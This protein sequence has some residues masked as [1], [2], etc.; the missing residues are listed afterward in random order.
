MQKKENN[1][2]SVFF[3]TPQFVTHVLD[4]L[5]DANLKPT[6]IVTAHEKP[7][8]R[9]LL[10]KPSPVKVWGQEHGVEVREPEKMDEAFIA[11]LGTDFDLFIV[12]GYGK[13]LP[14]ELLKL[15]Q[16]GTLNVHPS[17]LPKF[18]GP[19]PIESQILEDSK[20]VGVSVIRLD[21]ETDHGPILAQKSFSPS[22]WPMMRSELEELLWSEGGN[23]LA[24]SIPPYIE[25]QL[26]PEEQNHVL[27]TFTPKLSKADGLLD[28]SGDSYKNYL[29]YCAYERWPGTYFFTERNGKKVQVS[30][31]L[32][33]TSFGRD[34]SKFSPRSSL[35]RVKITEAS[36]ENGTFK[37]LRVIPEGKG[38][39]D[40]SDFLRGN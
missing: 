16:H 17:L 32:S 28:L 25:E 23:L 27:A 37:L 4:A 39:M 11:S 5:L 14:P 22:R 9:G 33:Q 26:K 3:G 19:S 13:I 8:G 29:K 1:I 15:P 10:P 35:V 24:E 2:R 21:E 34:E 7:Q 38:E 31:T 6:L 18:R 30:E 36:F 12:A 40:Y 20:E